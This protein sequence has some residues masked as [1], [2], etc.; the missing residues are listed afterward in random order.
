MFVKKCM[1][2][3]LVRTGMTCMWGSIAVIVQ[4]PYK[5]FPPENILSPARHSDALREV[6]MLVFIR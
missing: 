5:N 1:A 6:H 4:Q 2:L 3:S